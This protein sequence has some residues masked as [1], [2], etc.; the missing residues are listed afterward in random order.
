MCSHWID[1][2][3]GCR[4]EFLIHY[5]PCC[6]SICQILRQ[7]CSHFK[8][9]PLSLHIFSFDELVMRS[10]RKPWAVRLE[11]VWPDELNR[12]HRISSKSHPKWS[13][14][15]YVPNNRLFYL[16]LG[17]F[18]SHTDSHYLPKLPKHFRSD[19]ILCFK[20]E[21]GYRISPFV[22]KFLA[23]LGLNLQVPHFL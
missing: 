10:C 1:S 6:G 3:W 15:K 5:R 20:N 7:G 2:E 8:S 16:V 12:N 21:I 13:P 11:T 17:L 23:K 19:Q 18:A 9:T 14:T 22:D 4:D